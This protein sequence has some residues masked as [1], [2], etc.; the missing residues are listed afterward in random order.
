MSGQL[1]KAIERFTTVHQ[2]E[3]NNLEAILSLAD[4]YERSGEKDKAISWYNKCLPLINIPGLK[5][6]VK[7][8][9]AA[10]EKK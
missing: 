4:A 10:L 9:V 7:R 1:D 8:R 2:S 5:E 6:E 3:P